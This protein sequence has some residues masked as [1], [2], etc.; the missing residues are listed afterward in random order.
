VNQQK[1]LRRILG[2]KETKNKN[3]KEKE[4]KIVI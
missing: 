2:T 1:Q 3:I 4:K